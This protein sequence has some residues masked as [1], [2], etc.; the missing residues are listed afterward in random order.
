MEK[1]QR[2]FMLNRKTNQIEEVSY[3]ELVMSFCDE[4]IEDI[5]VVKRTLFFF[6]VWDIT[7]DHKLIKSF[8]H[9]EEANDFIFDFFAKIFENSVLNINFPIFSFTKENLENYI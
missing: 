3:K 2:V 4:W 5:L 6:E 9:L 7:E 1:E 8:Q